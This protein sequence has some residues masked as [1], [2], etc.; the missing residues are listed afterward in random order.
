MW[1]Q[2]RRRHLHPRSALSGVVFCLTTQRHNFSHTHALLRKA[3]LVTLF[4]H[5]GAQE[6]QKWMRSCLNKIILTVSL[7]VHTHKK[8]QIV[9]LN[10]KKK[11]WADS[12]AKCFELQWWGD[13]RNQ[14][15]LELLVCLCL[16]E[17]NKIDRIHWLLARVMTSSFRMYSAFF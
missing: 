8:N 11:K 13:L 5:T 10:N 2:R 12:V 3:A 7:A 9:N 1:L 4:S 16:M 14:H 15:M 17:T 6:L